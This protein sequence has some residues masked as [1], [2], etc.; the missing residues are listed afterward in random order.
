MSMHVYSYD[1]GVQK[2]LLFYKDS[3]ITVGID[4]CEVK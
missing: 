3:K 4:N 2:K 1:K